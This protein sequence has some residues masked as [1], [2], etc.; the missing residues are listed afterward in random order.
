MSEQENKEG[1]VTPEKKRG[2]MEWM[3]DKYRATNEFL[4]DQNPVLGTAAG[5]AAAP[6]IIEGGKSVYNAGRN[7][8]TGGAKM[9]VEEGT[10]EAVKSISRG[11]SAKLRV[12][13]R[14]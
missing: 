13:I 4:F 14:K 10:N 5:A 2:L 8:A 9:I 7:L 12:K 11:R 1:S 6:L 3:G